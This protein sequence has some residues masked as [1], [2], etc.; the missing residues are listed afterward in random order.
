MGYCV[1]WVF[2]S[3]EDGHGG[4]WK[5]TLTKD[6]ALKGKTFTVKL[7]SFLKCKYEEAGCPEKL[8]TPWRRASPTQKKNGALHYLDFK[9]REQLRDAELL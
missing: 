8:G 5:A 6:G 1:E 7:N 3:A 2:G 4:A 9:V